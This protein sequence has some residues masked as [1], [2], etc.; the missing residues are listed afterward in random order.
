[1]NKFKV[2][3]RVRFKYKGEGPACFGKVTG[4]HVTQDMVDLAEDSGRQYHIYI[5]GTCGDEIALLEEPVTHKFKV[6]DRVRFKDGSKHFEGVGA[7]TCVDNWGVTYVQSEGGDDYSL[8]PNGLFGDRIELLPE[9]PAVTGLPKQVGGD[10]YAKMAITPT[11]YVL[12]N[13]IGWCEA[14]AI[15][16]LSRWKVKNGLQDLEKALHYVEILIAEVKAK[17]VV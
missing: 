2:G 8:Y 11:Q 17:G 16:Y 12:A 13:D 9:V 6:G 5:D 10:H 15:K 7:V 4:I 3:A 1:M 14:N